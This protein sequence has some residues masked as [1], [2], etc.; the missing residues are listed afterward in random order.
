MCVHKYIG[1]CINST[2]LVKDLDASGSNGSDR[3]VWGSFGS[4]APSST[5]ISVRSHSPTSQDF[6]TS[7]ILEQ[8]EGTL[9]EDTGYSN[10]E[11]AGSYLDQ[12]NYTLVDIMHMSR[13]KPC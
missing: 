9:E 7:A 2:E 11:I 1:S 4:D 10:N 6:Q 3:S 13:K 5:P 8:E 12:F